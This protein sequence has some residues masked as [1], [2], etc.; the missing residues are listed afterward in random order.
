MDLH[1]R[2]GFILPFIYKLSSW[3]TNLLGRTGIFLVV[4]LSGLPYTLAL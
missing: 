3:S 1:G 4:I 2:R